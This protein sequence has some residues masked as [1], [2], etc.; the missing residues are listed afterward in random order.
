MA[1]A[2]DKLIVKG[3]REHNL[4]DIYL[5]I[6]KNTLT[7]FCGV[8][9]SG[10]S[11][12]AFDTIYAEGQ[13]RY[14]ESLSAYARQ[15]LGQM[16]KPRY[17]WIRGLAPTISI[18]Q[19]AASKNPRSTVGTI[20]EIYDYLRLLWA[21]VGEQRC[22]QCGG[23]VEAGTPDTIV[24]DI[25]RAEEGS[26]FLL[27]APLITNRKGEHREV[28]DAARAQGFVRVRVD[29]EVR[30]LSETIELKKSY[31]HYIEVVVDRLAARAEARSRLQD[32]VEAALHV[33]R[34][35]LIVSWLDGKET[36]YSDRRICNR[37][38]LSFP[39]LEPPIF[40]F[41]S[42]L[43]MCPECNGI[44]TTMEVDP[45]KL[46][47]DENLSIREG[48]VVPWRS[49][50]DVAAATWASRITKAFCERFEIDLDRPFKRLSKRK[51]ELILQ[52]SGDEQFDV[53]LEGTK[54]KGTYRT[55][56][57]GLLPGMARRFAQTTSNRARSWYQSFQTNLPCATCEGHRLR[58][59]AQ[60]VFVGDR[61]IHEV[62][63]M[64]VAEAVAF[65][66]GL[67][68]EGNRA[69]VGEEILKEIH[70]RLRFLLDVGLSYLTLD[71]S[72]P[73]LS[74]GEAQRIRLAS[75]VGSELTGV[76]YVLDEPSI[77]LHQR[78]NLR[79]LST[80]EHLRDI[81]N[82]LIVVEHDEETIRRA[83]HI[84]EFGPGAGIKG[85][86]VVYSG[87]P[88]ALLRSNTLTG[89]YLSG[90]KTIDVPEK[91]RNGNGKALTIEG[92]RANNLKDI[93]VS[94]PLGKFVGVTG[95]SGAGK[96]SL[97]EQTLYPALA[98]HLHSSHL[99]I[100]EHDRIE[101][102]E[103]IDKVIDI[104]QSPIGRTP[105]S[106]PATYTKMFDEIRK[107][108]AKLPES[109]ARGYEPGRF[110]FNVKGGRCEACGGAGSVLVE[111]HFLADMYVPCQVCR[112]RRYNENTLQVF[113]RG[114]SIRDVLDMSVAEV[115]ELFQHH[116]K[117]AAILDTLID[118]GLEY[119]A[120]GQSA[121]TF[122][123][124]EAQRIKLSRE[125]AKRQTGRTFYILDEPTTGLHFEDIRKLLAVLNRLVEKGNTV[126]VI[127][128]NLD[129]IK[130]ADWIIDLGPEGGDAGGEVV[131]T[132]TPEEVAKVKG[133]HTGACL[134]AVV[135]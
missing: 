83:N 69:K 63:A 21:R 100:G 17:D 129:V 90:R 4:R 70:N 48:A 15:F 123:G 34:G 3:A 62:S 59:E 42:P 1:K 116:P 77:G 118:V 45:R 41:N 92:A 47:P 58:P 95:V 135:G 97:I 122:S 112:G 125:L 110:S 107:V 35:R 29:G 78:D 108:F 5:E 2:I 99:N 13:R 72:G 53:P 104:D 86:E 37:C 131:A 44:G 115:R 114:K 132:G 19:K 55:A 103:L 85:G 80:L 79:L 102:L 61:G 20:T 6:P 33:G 82:T 98:R 67:E 7:V 51:R 27:L 57:E 134:K 50:F 91:R 76:L 81:G 121:T 93:T 65:F 49:R 119:I 120:L 23:P 64:S 84:V 56:Y 101:G 18:E 87:K 11:S 26:R 54:L 96:S 39:E 14:V 36:A 12:L 16:E 128:H 117:I 109:R 89:Q 43:G 9:G 30:D 32:S 124:G 60:A 133:S 8:S 88:A 25:L 106:N 71:R 38:S 10:K 24:R 130:T 74:G 94:F 105:R 111:M 28:F 40:S 46:I 113:Y 52:G 73:T 22:H 126:V 127:E 66:A 68:L 75:Q 31:K